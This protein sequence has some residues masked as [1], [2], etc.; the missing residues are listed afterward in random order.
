MERNKI[1]CGVDVGAATAK[2]V[3]FRDNKISGHAVIPTGHNV[4][5]S[6]KDVT[7]QAIERS[8]LSLS[9]EELDLVLSTGYARNAVTFAGKSATEIICHA[10]GAHFMIPEARTIIDIGGKDSKTIEV[11]EKGKLKKI[12]NKEK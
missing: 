2:A 11:A 9:I 1:F 4:K 8:G 12:K 5:L 6:A 10:K 3:I 7:E